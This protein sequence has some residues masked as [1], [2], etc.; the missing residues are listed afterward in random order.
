MAGRAAWPGAVILVV[1]GLLAAQAPIGWSAG[2]AAGLFLLGLGWSFTL[3]AGSTLVV[4][5][6]PLAERAGAQGASDL[7]MGLAA[8]GGGALAGVVVGQLGYAVLGAVRRASPPS[9]AMASLLIRVDAL[10][11]PGGSTSVSPDPVLPRT[12][13]LPD[14]EG[15]QVG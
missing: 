13:V 1:A 6:V 5:S 9:S 12:A 10:G 4:K 8:G 11:R 3:V 15:D 2:L 14:R 7:V